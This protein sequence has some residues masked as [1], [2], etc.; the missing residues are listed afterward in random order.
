MK[1]C[2]ETDLNGYPIKLE[3]RSNGKFKVTYGFQ[4]DDNLSYKQGTEK[5]G[6]AI[7]HALACESKLDNE[8]D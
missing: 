2:F 5:L 6:E 4:V 1:T 3:Q 7:F 8:V